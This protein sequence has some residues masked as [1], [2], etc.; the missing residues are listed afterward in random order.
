MRRRVP[1]ALCS[2]GD[3]RSLFQLLIAVAGLDALLA[4]TSWLRFGASGTTWLALEALLLAGVAALCPRRRWSAALVSIAALATAGVVLLGLGDRLTGLSLARSLN[5]YLD[6]RLLPAVFDLGAGQAGTSMAVLGILA[7]FGA[8]LGLAGLAAWLLLRTRGTGRE[9]AGRWL[10][11]GMIVVALAAAWLQPRGAPRVDTPGW[12]LAVQQVERA[13]A[14]RAEGRAFADALAAAEGGAEARPLPG[15]AGVDVVVG[16]IESYGDSALF[17]PRYA[18]AIRPAL[19]RIGDTLA[20]AGLHAASGRVEA[21]SQGGQSWFGHGSFLSGLWLDSQIRYDLMVTSGRATLIDDLEATGHESIGV[22]PA[23]VRPWAAG[24]VLGYDRLLDATTI[25]YAGPSLNWVTMPDQYTWH[26]IQQARAAREQPVFIEAALISSHAPWVP[27]LPVLD[28]ERIGDG[29]VFQRWAGAGDPPAVVWRDA[30]RVR[31]HFARALA[32][33]VEVAG[34]YAARHV[35]EDTLL[36]LLG[37]HQPA[38]L[39]TGDDASLAVPVHVISGD[40]TLVRAFRERGFAEGMLPAGSGE[41]PRM[42]VLR[43]WLHAAFG[44]AATVAEA[45]PADN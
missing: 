11:L 6:W 36:V 24:Q 21:P 35:D 2:D 26:V 38:P 27:I 32:Y 42:A 7:A 19:E 30:E 43:E 1:V 16:F 31:R 40:P 29:R 37:D 44:E 41:A 4:A 12:H 8:T 9:G 23:I 28:W 34:E 15:L 39:I 10:A 5:V 18:S 33:A 17:D 45:Q 3:S 22:M 13:L 14:T 25:D 20:G